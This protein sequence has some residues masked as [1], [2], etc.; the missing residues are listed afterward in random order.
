MVPPP[1]T[2]D[3]TVRSGR[4]CHSDPGRSPR[5]AAWRSASIDAGFGVT[6]IA[7]SVGPTA[8]DVTVTVAKPETVPLVA[9]I[10]LVNVPVTVP[11]VKRPVFASML[12]PPFT[13]DQIGVIAN[14]VAARI[15]SNRDELLRGVGLH[16]HWVRRHRDGRERASVGPFVTVTVARATNAPTARANRI[17]V[18]AGRAARGE[19]TRRGV[20]RAA[21]RDHRPC[22]RDRNDVAARVLPTAVNCCVAPCSQR[23]DSA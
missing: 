5:T 2:T 6:V 20:D 13:T 14:D 16:G 4:C 1:F 10:V 7:V 21:T 8:A 12:P 15:L 3:Q 17:D 9:L 19:E 18:Y 22:R 11:A 23:P